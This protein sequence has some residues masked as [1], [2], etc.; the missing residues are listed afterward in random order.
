[1]IGKMIT[2]NHQ[3][4]FPKKN[5]NPQNLKNLFLIAT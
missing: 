3:I 1:M 5:S 4:M 2:L